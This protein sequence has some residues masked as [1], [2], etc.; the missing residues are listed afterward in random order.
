MTHDISLSAELASTSAPT[1][2]WRV[3][4]QSFTEKSPLWVKSCF[5][6]INKLNQYKNVIDD[7][8]VTD[9]DNQSVDTDFTSLTTY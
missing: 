1:R 7:L 9:T 3:W 4:R 6:N 8:N 5:Y 2:V